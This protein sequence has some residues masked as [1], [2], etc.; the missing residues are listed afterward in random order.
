MDYD[1]IADLVGQIKFHY[2]RTG[3]WHEA[4]CTK[5]FEATKSIPAMVCFQ[6][7]VPRDEQEE[8]VQKSYQQVFKNFHSIQENYAFPKY[9]FI[10]CNNL[11]R[12]FWQKRLASGCVLTTN[13]ADVFQ[14]I[15]EKSNSRWNSE[16]S[17]REDLRKAIDNLPELH[18]TAIEL[19][20]FAGMTSREISRVL[21]CNMN[22][23]NSRIRRGRSMLR[24]MLED[25]K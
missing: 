25:Y 8:I 7:N 13:D 18:R 21:N 17:L 24:K 5:L 2:L 9:L 3:S 12:R 14:K 22:T 15:E 6:R 11:C 1:Q 20:Y 16:I 10:V 19:F 23:V 4:L